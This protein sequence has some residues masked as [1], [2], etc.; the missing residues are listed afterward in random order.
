MRE[1]LA[2]LAKILSHTN[3][4]S[5]ID[6]SAEKTA[7]S[8]RSVCAR[9]AKPLS[10]LPDTKSPFIIRNWMQ[11]NQSGW[12]FLTC[13]PDERAM[14]KG[15]LRVW[16]SLAIRSLQA[17]PIDLDRRRWF[18]IDEL[19]ALDRVDALQ[20]LVCESRKYGGCAALALQSP[21]QLQEIYSRSL[22]RTITGNCGTRVIFS[23]KDSLTAKDI[24]QCLGECDLKEQQEG[25]SYGAHEMRDG[26][27]I[28]SHKRSYPCIPPHKIMSLKPNYAYVMLSG[29]IPLFKTKITT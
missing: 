13:K 16:L 14:V 9:F 18:V 11:S 22:Q 10:H 4:A 8:M 28:S 23:E 1:P 3:A 20:T 29:N 21:T 26:V 2:Y 7:G 27:S 17:L 25:I 24:S 6:L 5:F 12:L 15:L 19:P